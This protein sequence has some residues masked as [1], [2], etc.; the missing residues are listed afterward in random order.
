MCTT[1]G[2]GENLIL[3][4]VGKSCWDLDVIREIRLGKKKELNSNCENPEGESFLRVT[5]WETVNPLQN[6]MPHC[7]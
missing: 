3:C 5:Q 6:Q 7:K 4:E 1:G 2:N